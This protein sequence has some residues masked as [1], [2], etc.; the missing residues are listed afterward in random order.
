MS[1]E[2]W[3]LASPGQDGTHGGGQAPHCDPTQRDQWGGNGVVS[4]PATEVQ[5]LGGQQRLQDAHQAE[6]RA[7]FGNEVH[8]ISVW[9]E[10]RR[11]LM[12]RPWPGTEDG[13]TRSW[14]FHE[15]VSFIL[16]KIWMFHAVKSLTIL[17]MWG[18][19]LQNNCLGIFHAYMHTFKV[20]GPTSAVLLSFKNVKKI[21]FTQ[22][23][24]LILFVKLNF[25]ILLPKLFSMKA[26]FGQIRFFLISLIHIKS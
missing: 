23:T 1:W 2:T 15:N 20:Q 14:L 25:S 26:H 10:I 22:I 18:K 9:T 4:H 6:S 17:F 7:A 16:I 13:K 12:E 19:L 8:L 21:C 24:I 5:L 3:W 11:N